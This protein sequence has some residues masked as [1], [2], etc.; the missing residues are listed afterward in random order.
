MLLYTNESHEDRGGFVRLSRSRTLSMICLL[1]I[2]Y[3]VI[4]PATSAY[5][6]SDQPPG[7][8]PNHVI[9]IDAGSQ[10]LY[11]ARTHDPGE[12]G[13]ATVSLYLQVGPWQNPQ[14][15]Y[16]G[17][18]YDMWQDEYVRSDDPYG[19][20]VYRVDYNVEAR[21]VD[22]SGGD[23]HVVVKA[24]SY[25]IYHLYYK[26]V[27]VNQWYMV[28]QVFRSATALPGETNQITGS[29]D[30]V[31][32]T[33]PASNLQAG[34]MYSVDMYISWNYKHAEDPSTWVQVYV[35]QTSAYFEVQAGSPV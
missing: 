7:Q 11:I 12:I 20:F 2:T 9:W 17:W 6:W 15:L 28:D 25:I 23:D 27:G 1:A 31:D 8:Q 33:I 24:L 5:W 21:L 22:T 32:W 30:L 3:I 16:P 34:D 26:P 13:G 4:A 29:I 19:H 10:S 18:E 35:D 14:P